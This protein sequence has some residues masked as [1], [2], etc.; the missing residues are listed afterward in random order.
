MCYLDI[1]FIPQLQQVNNSVLFF[2]DENEGSGGT[3]RWAE[4]RLS[5]ETLPQRIYDFNLPCPCGLAL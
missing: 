2:S 3:T 5:S 4:H 1:N